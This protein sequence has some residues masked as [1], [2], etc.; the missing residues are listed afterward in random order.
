MFTVSAN[1]PAGPIT[2]NYTIATPTCSSSKRIDP[3]VPTILF[4]HPIYINQHIWHPQLSDENLRRFN[5]VT[6]DL[7]GHGTTIG[8][9]PSWFR[10]TDAGEDIYHFMKAL[11]LPPLHLVGLSMGACTA[12]QV[13]V[14]HPEQVLTLTLIAPLPLEEP[15]DVLEGRQEIY[16]AWEAAVDTPDGSVDE[17]ALLHAAYGGVQLGCN[18]RKGPLIDAT[19]Q[20]AIGHCVRNWQK[21]SLTDLHTLSVKFFVDRKPHP[22]EL[23]KRATCNMT[24]IHCG[25]DIAYP[26]ELAEELRD[27]VERAGLPV[28]LVSIPDAPHFGSLTNWA[29]VN[30]VILDTVMSAVQTDVPPASTTVSPFEQ[31]FAAGGCPNMGLDMSDS[32]ED[33]YFF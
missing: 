22:I 6:L 31:E 4:L 5:L 19:V 20:I 21:E 17:E 2:F 26:I 12:L 10:R 9:T 32:D 15:Q 3:S 24:I 28:E 7:R 27:R 1:P 13:S 25:A 8:S 11:D 16:D 18:G 33:D 29:E 14:T 23:L 30:P